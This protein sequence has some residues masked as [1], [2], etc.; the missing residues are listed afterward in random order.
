MESSPPSLAAAERER[1]ASEVVRVHVESEI[2]KGILL[3]GDLLDEDALASWFRISRAPVR[4]AILELSANGIVTIVPSAG[5]HVSRAPISELLG[6]MELLAELEGACAKLATRRLTADSTAALGRMQARIASFDEVDVQSYSRSNVDFHE[7]LY[8][9]CCNGALTSEIARTRRRTQVF[10]R[11][12]FQNPMRIG[13]SK[14]EHGRIIAAM[15]DGDALGASELMTEH[16]SVGGRA[17]ADLLSSGAPRLLASDV[18]YPG[19]QEAEFG[20]VP[21]AGVRGDRFEAIVDERSTLEGVRRYLIANTAQTPTLAGA[22]A[23]MNMSTRTL[24]RRLATEGTTFQ[25]VKDNSRREVAV[26]RIAHSSESVAQIA[27]DLGFSDTPAF[28]RA[29]RAWTGATPRAF[30]TPQT[31]F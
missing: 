14:I 25:R 10:R 13:R 19:R 21:S 31:T 26:Y 18:E 5:I 11:T 29:F 28:Y 4:Q 17:F 15:L 1:S 9:A 22:A 2:S 23:S 30:R 27:Y 3:P 20:R 12:V 7:F 6:L 16:I 8:R 24:T